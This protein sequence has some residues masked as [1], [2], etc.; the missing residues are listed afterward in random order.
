MMKFCSLYSGSNGNSVF[1]SDHGSRIL[2]DAGLSGKLIDEALI[3][4]EEDP[5]KL[6]GILITHEHMD[7]IMSAGIL[8]RRYNIPI[9]A[10][11]LTWDSMRTV[12]GSIDEKNIKFFENEKEF[13]I[14]DICARA[15]PISHDAKD[16]V[17]FRIKVTN[18]EIAI[19][20]DIGKMTRSLLNNLENSDILLLES[21][22]DEE[23]LKFAKY[24]YFL[25]RRIMSEKGHLSNEMAGKV[26][27]YLAEKGM[28]KFILGHLSEKSNFP[29]LVYQTVKGILLE[30]KIEI[31]KDINLTIAKRK[32][33]GT[34]Y[35]I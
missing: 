14:G 28:T 32:A 12:I 9:F 26:V 6:N 23:M 33:I 25:K 22:H 5:K 30:K 18:N 11:E 31:G 20:T 17:G 34:V 27:A 4:I 3:A 7:H 21:N 1:I 10:N 35:N 13:S 24:P 29:E 15:F 19:A 2:V 16:P 8:S